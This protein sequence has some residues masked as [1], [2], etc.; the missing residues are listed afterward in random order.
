MENDT[1]PA[2]ETQ[3]V[4]QKTEVVENT[5]AEDAQKEPKTAGEGAEA[6]KKKKKKK[7]KKSKFLKQI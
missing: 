1:A 5:P 6:P 7:K 4:E 3:E 2:P